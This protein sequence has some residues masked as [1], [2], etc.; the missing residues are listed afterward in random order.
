MHPRSL[1]LI[2]PRIESILH[3]PLTKVKIRLGGRSCQAV[4]VGKKG[5][6]ERRSLDSK[7]I[8]LA[9]HG[10]VDGFNSGVKR[11]W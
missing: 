8:R 9:A 7:A 6:G 5:H 3:T 4:P 1:T 11:A 2:S 10:G